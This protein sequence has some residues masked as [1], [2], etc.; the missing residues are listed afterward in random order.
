MLT[1][2]TQKDPTRALASKL[3]LLRPV[4]DVIKARNSDLCFYLTNNYKKV[5]LDL[6]ETIQY[7]FKGTFAQCSR[8]SINTQAIDSPIW[9]LDSK[10]RLGR[11]A[12]KERKVIDSVVI[13]IVKVNASA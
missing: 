2:P 1:A 7:S 12:S 5:S 10:D 6:S 9:I 4:H 13:E 8:V 11:N 3:S